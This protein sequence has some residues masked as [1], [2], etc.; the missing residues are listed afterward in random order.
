MRSP[1]VNRTFFP[2]RKNRYPRHLRLTEPAMRPMIAFAFLLLVGSL[3]QHQPHCTLY[4]ELRVIAAVSFELALVYMDDHIDD[5][6]KKIAIVRDD[7]QGAGVALEPL[8]KPD[9]GV[10]V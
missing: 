7:D 1:P 4:L 10:Q 9:D 2:P 6:I 3:V 8:F 5:A